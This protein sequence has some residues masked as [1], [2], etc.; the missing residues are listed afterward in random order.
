MTFLTADPE[1]T[2]YLLGVF[3]SPAMLK[4]EGPWPSLSK[5]VTHYPGEGS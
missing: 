3:G 1:P 2:H 5:Q 4:D